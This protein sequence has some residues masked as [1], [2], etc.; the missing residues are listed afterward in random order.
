VAVVARNAP[1]PCGS[2]RKHKLCCGTTRTQE[3]ASREALEILSGLAGLFPL[4]RP[5]S[6]AFEQ[7][8]EAHRDDPSI[9]RELVDEA[10][11]LLDG[12]EL[13]RIART[14]AREFPEVWAGL[15][16]DVGGEVDAEFA[17]LAGAVVTALREERRIDV[18]ALELLHEDMP[19]DPAET[20]ALCI[21]PCA[22]WS[23]LEADAADTALVAAGENE[24]DVVLASESARLGTPQHE[25]RLVLLVGRVRAQLPVL[26]FRRVSRAIAGACDSFGRDERVRARLA[27]MLL[28]DALGPLRLLTRMLAA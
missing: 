9:T 5:D 8:A 26:G 14:H 11:S 12:A 21:D 7:W 3:R 18:V 24:W 28:G 17:V 15:V 2:G 13:E 19:D 6:A 16:A 22:L 10:L 25:R 23:A 27:W 20:L 4:L 1:C